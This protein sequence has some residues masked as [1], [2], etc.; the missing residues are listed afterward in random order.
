MELLW[1]KQLDRALKAKGDQ[2]VVLLD[3]G[4]GMGFSAMR[5]A[6]QPIY[7][8]A[9]QDRRLVVAVSNLGFMP[10]DEPDADGYTKIARLMQ[11][12]NQA[13]RFTPQPYTE[14]DLRFVQDNQNLVTFVDASVLELYNDTSSAPVP[15]KNNIDILHESRALTHTQVPDIAL[16]TFAGLLSPGGVLYLD[17]RRMS[18][19]RGDAI[20]LA[21][22]RTVTIDEKYR[23]QRELSL[24]V[25]LSLLPRMGV[26][27]TSEQPGTKTYVRHT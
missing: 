25:G 2:P 18:G 14:Q 26:V 11:A 6:S 12:D 13:R 3:F 8:K 10:Q 27:P 23:E 15:L 1:T 4:G 16:A 5:V 19:L 7:K 21:D 22:G 9:I 17:V 20:D 24:E